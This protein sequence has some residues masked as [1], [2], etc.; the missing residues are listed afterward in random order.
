MALTASNTRVA[1]TGGIYHADSG[2]TLPSNAT[3]ALDAAFLAGEV[4]YATDE[5]ITQSIE[6]DTADIVAW[7]NAETVRRVRT[8]HTL[9]Y[10]FTMLE[11]NQVTRGLVGVTAGTAS[12]GST[13]IRADHS[14]RGAWVIAVIDGDHRIRIVIPDGEV[15]ELGET[16]YVSGEA[17]TY[18]ITITCYADNNG[19][20]AIIYH[21]VVPGS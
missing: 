6:T 5:G 16:T 20:K 7:Q 18:P 2:T 13:K 9:T 1:V 10:A 3:T 15:T 19:D 8:G 21:D 12:S 14:I 17:I 4:G 11:T